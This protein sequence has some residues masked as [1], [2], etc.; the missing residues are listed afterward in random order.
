MAGH[1][2]TNTPEAL[3]GA[4]LEKTVLGIYGYNVNKKEDI[5]NGEVSTREDG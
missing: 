4:L 5:I 3:V 1:S 2:K